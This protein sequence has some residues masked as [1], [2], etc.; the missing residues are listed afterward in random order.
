MGSRI[1]EVIN[2][3]RVKILAEAQ[4][5]LQACVGVNTGLVVA[6]NLGSSNRLNYSVIGDTVNLAAR[7]ESLTRLY[8]V[9]NIVSEASVLAAPDFIYRQ[10]DEVRVAGKTASIT[11]YELIGKPGTLTA[12][13]EQELASYGKALQAYRSGHWQ[14]AEDL[15][16]QLRQK[17]DNAPVESDLSGSNYPFI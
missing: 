2:G 3:V 15:F 5:E 12:E 14:A 9:S 7:L 6:G 13:K 11:I 16:S 4:T 1:K 17:C 8:N 10:L